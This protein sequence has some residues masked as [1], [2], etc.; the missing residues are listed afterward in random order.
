MRRNLFVIVAEDGNEYNLQ[1]HM[2]DVARDIHAFSRLSCVLPFLEQRNVGRRNDGYQRADRFV[3]ESR[4]N[5]PP[6]TRPKL[7]FTH[8][9]TIAEKKADAFDRLTFFVVLPVDSEDMID[10]LRVADNIDVHSIHRGPEDAS[11]SIEL[12]LQPAQQILRCVVLL[13]WPWRDS[14]LLERHSHKLQVLSALSLRVPRKRNDVFGKSTS[15]QGG[16]SS[17]TGHPFVAE[18][19]ANGVSRAPLLVSI[20]VTAASAS[21]QVSRAFGD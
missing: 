12:I 20:S 1:D 16:N 7:P 15:C 21:R 5:H 11:E 14:H 18:R 4:L 3:V 10:V 9:Q 2:T 19:R 8:H 13:G 17:Q 6:L